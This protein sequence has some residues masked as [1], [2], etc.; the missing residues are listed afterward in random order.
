M[1]DD[2]PIALSDEVCSNLKL[3]GS[4]TEN[5]KTQGKGELLE[6]IPMQGIPVAD[7]S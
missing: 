2:Y 3:R 4:E 1:L 6:G 5:W 7:G